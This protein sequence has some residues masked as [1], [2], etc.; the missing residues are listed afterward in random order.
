MKLWTKLEI[1]DSEIENTVTIECNEEM[2]A[3]HIAVDELT[4][5]KEDRQHV[6]L[7]FNKEQLTEL[8]KHLTHF[9]DMI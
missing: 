7:Y 5:E 6:S 2:N 1:T 4:G 9:R 3:C 8:I